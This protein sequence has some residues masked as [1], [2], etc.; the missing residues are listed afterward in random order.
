MNAP[1]IQDAAARPERQGHHRARPQ[2]RVAV[3]HA[4]LSVRDRAR[5]RRGRRGRRRQP[6]PR[7][8]RRHRRQLDRRQSHPEVV[9]AITEQAQKFIHMSGTD[10]YYEP[11]VRLAEELAS[12]AP[13]D[14]DVRTF[15]AQLRH[16][17]DRSGDQ[18]GALSH[19]AAGHDRVPRRVPR[20]LAGL[21]V[22]DREQGRSSAAASVR[23]CPACITR[24]IR[25]STA[26]PAAPTR[27]PTQCLAFIDRSDLRAPRRRPTRSPRSSSSRS[28]ARAAT[29]SPP[30]AFLQGLRELTHEARHPARR[31]RGAVGHGADREDV[32]LGAL[33][34]EGATSSTSR[35][36]SPRACRSASRARAP[37]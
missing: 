37:T 11:Q 8:R 15:F 13:I 23:S 27:A 26:S 4:R 12:I 25:T 10:F 16:R 31:R 30:P 21:A 33:R 3:L 17:G 5:R 35:R 2:V 36:G 6:L 32:R 28:R 9:E 19:Q 24:R 20:P 7:L 1:D 34:P 29:S 14:G 22:A 18:A